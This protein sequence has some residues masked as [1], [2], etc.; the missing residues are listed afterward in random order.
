MYEDMVTLWLRTALDSDD[1]G[2]LLVSVCL[3][4]ESKDSVKLGSEGSAVVALDV[5]I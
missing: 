4:E 1:E 3:D 5:D 2:E